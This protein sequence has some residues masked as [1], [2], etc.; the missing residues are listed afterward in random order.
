MAEA[1][2]AAVRT[3]LIGTTHVLLIVSGD[4]AFGGDEEE[5]NYAFDWFSDLYTHISEGC[6]ATC[7]IICCPGNHDVDHSE[8]RK[9]R[10]ALTDKIRQDP[11][12][13]DDHDI[14][15]ECTKEQR[16]FFAF[17]EAL[18]GDEI[19]V[20]DD[21]LLR[22]HRL[23]DDD[24]IVQINVFNTAWMSSLDEIPGTIVYPIENYRELL[25][26]PDGFSISILHHP[27]GWFVTEYSRQ[28]REELTSSS[29][30][31]MFGHEHVPDSLRPLTRFGDHVRILEGGVL[32]GDDPN[33]SSFNLLLLDTHACRVK[34]ATF[35]RMGNRYVGQED[36]DWQ[37]A[38]RLTSSESGQ[39]RLTPD[40]RLR[41]EDIGANILHPRQDRLGLRDIFVYPDLL[42][43]NTDAATAHEKLNKP[44]QRKPLYLVQTSLMYYLKVTRTQENQHYCGCILWS[45]INAERY[46]C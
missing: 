19:L 16:A 13:A 26:K 6:N 34:N 2:S 7:W 31:V 36:S 12:L 10:T 38:T 40:A 39:F 3:E 4:I 5:Y 20:H 46:L 8:E 9:M 24:S 29:S 32:R 27:L 35:R 21:P 44:F 45:F 28:L 30:V 18:E 1:I 33:I 42:P 41:L 17:R 15:K 22:I 14:V 43:V 11:T 25:Q 23:R 37:D